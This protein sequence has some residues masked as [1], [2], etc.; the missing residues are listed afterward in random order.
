MSD[1]HELVETRPAFAWDCPNCGAE[2][3]A[4]AV[5]CELSEEEM[6]ELRDEHGVQ[7]WETGN[8]LVKPESVSCHSCKESF[9]TSNYED[10]QEAED[11]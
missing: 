8:F 4:R 6:R 2:N 11:G 5:V 7:P 1:L 10:S 3:F 9:L